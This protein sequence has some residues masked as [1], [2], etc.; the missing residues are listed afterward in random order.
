[1]E[2]NYM[3]E[4]CD[5]GWGIFNGFFAE[6]GGLVAEDCAPYQART[7]GDKC[8]NYAKCPSVAKV[9]KS[10]YVGGYHNELTVLQIQ[11][12]MLMRGPVVTEFKCDNNFAMYSSGVMMQSE[13]EGNTKKPAQKPAENMSSSDS[14]ELFIPSKGNVD[15]V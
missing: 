10:Y 6:N 7:K 9:S 8:S 15:F 2:C 14:D 11:K 4:G 5:G 13:G 1:M 3:N 12:E